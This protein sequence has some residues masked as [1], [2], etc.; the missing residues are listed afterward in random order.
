M[1]DMKISTLRQ[2]L[3]LHYV[4]LVDLVEMAELVG[5]FAA[6]WC[7]KRLMLPEAKLDQFSDPQG[8][9]R[10][11]LEHPEYSASDFSKESWVKFWPR[12]VLCHLE[13]A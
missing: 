12:E 4:D 7:Q 6:R 11:H 13:Q 3:P 9:L 8:K 5:S 2:K 10:V 1:Q